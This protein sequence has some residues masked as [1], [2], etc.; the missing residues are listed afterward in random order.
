MKNAFL[1]RIFQLGFWTTIQDVPPL[2][3]E[4]FWSSKSNE[5]FCK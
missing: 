5:F 3:L 2:I 4:N 1:V